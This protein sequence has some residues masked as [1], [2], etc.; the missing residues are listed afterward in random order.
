MYAFVN[1]TRKDPK[2]R[3]KLNDTLD[4]YMRVPYNNQ[5][6]IDYNCLIQNV[7]LKE[8]INIMGTTIVDI[9]IELKMKISKKE[10]L[11]R[12]PAQRSL[13]EFGN[14]LYSKSSGVDSRN[15]L[16]NL[17]QSIDFGCSS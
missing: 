11:E 1:V 9:D 2:I 13:K 7:I 4:R 12:K 6:K 5:S 3:I 17:R 8:L 16:I 15:L 10:Y 14:H